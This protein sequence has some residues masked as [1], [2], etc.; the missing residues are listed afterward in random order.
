MHILVKIDK[1]E[2]DGEDKPI[3][4]GAEVSFEVEPEYLKEVQGFME[5]TRE[6]WK[7]IGP[8]LETIGAVDTIRVVMAA[9]KQEVQAKIDALKARFSATQPPTD[10]AVN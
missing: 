3:I 2:V 7:M 10:P 9:V 5:Q 1:F 4:Q 8:A 6:N